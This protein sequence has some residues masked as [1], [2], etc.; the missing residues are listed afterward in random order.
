[1]CLI[2]MCMDAH[3]EVEGQFGGIV[4][5]A[6]DDTVS[7]SFLQV[8]P[9]KWYFGLSI[10]VKSKKELFYIYDSSK[11]STQMNSIQFITQSFP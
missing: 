6:A 5:L 7:T 9:H 4:G 8:A 1:M 11:H 3:I 10:T 2:I